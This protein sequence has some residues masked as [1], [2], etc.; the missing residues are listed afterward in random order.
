MAAAARAAVA[1]AAGTLA[2][3][4]GRLLFSMPTC[5][6]W[7][8]RLPAPCL[9]CTVAHRDPWSVEPQN[10]STASGRFASRRGRRVPVASRCGWLTA[11]VPRTGALQGGP[12]SDRRAAD[13]HVVGQ[14]LHA[15]PL[16]SADQPLN[17][18]LHL[19]L[20]HGLRQ[21]HGQRSLV[22]RQQVLQAQG[23][24]LATPP[25]PADPVATSCHTVIRLEIRSPPQTQPRRRRGL[26]A[27]RFRRIWQ[28]VQVPALRGCCPRLLWHFPSWIA[29]K[30]RRV[31]RRSGLLRG[32]TLPGHADSLALD[33][34]AFKRSAAERA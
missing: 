31:S 4:T 5:P 23:C 12:G 14:L 7:Q 27:A 1:V 32:L 22:P 29:T 24:S 26:S 34:G 8:S 3:T 16:R 19:R 17:S 9:S 33:N 18:G 2:A 25:E 21:Q 30:R 15:V 6:G 10:G 13:P 20:H 11:A 28:I